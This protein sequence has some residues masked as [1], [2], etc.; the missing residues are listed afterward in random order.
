MPW[1][2]LLHACLA[3]AVSRATTLRRHVAGRGQSPYS[4][5]PIPGS[6]SAPGQEEMMDY[7]LFAKNLEKLS[8]AEA[9]EADE[10]EVR[11]A[12][13][14]SETESLKER[15]AAM[16]QRIVSEVGFLLAGAIRETLER[17]P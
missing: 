4:A 11:A 2:N 10:R 15:E 14:Q 16:R 8:Q 6:S 17:K 9:A 3:G 1:R 12:S 5:G 13:I 7:T